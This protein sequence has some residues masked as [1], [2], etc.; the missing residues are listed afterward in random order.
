MWV[1]SFIYNN[2][3]LGFESTQVRYILGCSNNLNDLFYYILNYNYSDALT[4]WQ[5]LYKHTF[6]YEIEIENMKNNTST[7]TILSF[8]NNETYIDLVNVVLI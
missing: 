6:D 3:I 7:G 1:A 2:T 5:N 8:N 4:E